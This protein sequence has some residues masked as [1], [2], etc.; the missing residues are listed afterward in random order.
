MYPMVCFCKIGHT[1]NVNYSNPH[2]E[3]WGKNEIIAYDRYF[4]S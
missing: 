4:K 1:S 3:V 2:P